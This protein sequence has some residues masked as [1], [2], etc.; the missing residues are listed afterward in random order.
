MENKTFYLGNLLSL[1][2]YP[3]FTEKSLNLY[4]SQQYTF[5][6]D[7]SLKKDQIKLILENVF[8]IK[9]LKVNTAIIPTKKKRVGRFIGKQA[10]YKKAYIKLRKGDKIAELLN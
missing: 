4:N 6:V 7:R 8:N 9:I 2:K 3:S 1:I 5:I 10:Q